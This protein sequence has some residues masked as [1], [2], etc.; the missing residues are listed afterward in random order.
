MQS[1]TWS[2]LGSF[3]TRVF[4]AAWSV[5]LYLWI[6]FLRLVIRN[7]EPQSQVSMSLMDEACNNPW[8]TRISGS[9]QGCKSLD[10]ALIASWF[11]NCTNQGAVICAFI[12]SLLSRNSLCDL[13]W[14][15]MIFLP[16]CSAFG[17][18]LSPRWWSG[19]KRTDQ[20]SNLKTPLQPMTRP[21]SRPPSPRFTT[22]YQRSTFRERIKE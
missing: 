14:Q 2:F 3:F 6:T 17:S 8:H 10:L 16:F 1:V 13:E 20:N 7:K 19:L 21:T 18:W 5:P 15:L 11:P 9:H 22:N 12:V 4:F